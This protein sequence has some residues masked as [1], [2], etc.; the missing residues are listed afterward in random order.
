MTEKKPSEVARNLLANTCE[1]CCES[2]SQAFIFHAFL[3]GALVEALS[4]VTEE[5][6][7]LGTIEHLAEMAQ[8]RVYNA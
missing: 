1:N 2:V 7:F 4:M 8:A 6:I 3:T 5:N